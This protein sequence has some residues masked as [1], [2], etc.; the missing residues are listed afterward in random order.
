MTKRITSGL[1][2]ILNRALGLTGEGAQ[3]TELDDGFVSQVLEIQ[4]IAAYSQAIGAHTGYFTTTLVNS[5][6][7]AGDILERFN[8]Y[9]PGT[10][11]GQFAGIDP[12]EF[13]MWF[14]GVS[15][16]VIS[17]TQ[18]IDEVQIALDTAGMNNMNEGDLNQVNMVFAR[19]DG[20]VAD[21][22]L[23]GVFL[24]EPGSL[25]AFSRPEF[26][27]LWPRDNDL[28]FLSQ[29]SGAGATVLRC[30]ILWAMV[31]RG[32]RPSVV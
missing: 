10:R 24:L 5:H 20:V 6:V 12:A 25:K 7:A 26:P 31:N 3:T 30:S 29:T 9:D 14:L 21:D 2:E 23:I 11:T 22:A 18:T 28:M 17:S 13:D 4:R 19:W 15:C 16:R 8:P 27:F 1:F 32:L